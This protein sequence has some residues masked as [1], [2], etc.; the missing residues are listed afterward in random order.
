MITCTGPLVQP[1]AT[2][3]TMVFVIG[4]EAMT[5]KAVTPSDPIVDGESHNHYVWTGSG[6]AAPA[7]GG[8][9]LF[10]FDADTGQ[11]V[12]IRTTA[13]GG[14]VDLSTTFPNSGSL[15]AVTTDGLLVSPNRS[16][17]SIDGEPAQLGGP[18]IAI[19]SSGETGAIGSFATLA[20]GTLV[21]FGGIPFSQQG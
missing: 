14:F 1:V 12:W 4:N 2:N 16:D 21:A 15:T 5:G 10:A 6:Q 8:Q 18:V 3:E 11:I 13:A 20:D 9:R 17:G 7:G 19:L